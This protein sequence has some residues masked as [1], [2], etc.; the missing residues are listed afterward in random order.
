MRR[1]GA[2]TE[3]ENV[4]KTLIS[5]DRRDTLWDDEI[6]PLEERTLAAPDV[7]DLRQA[8]AKAVKRGRS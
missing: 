6:V 7:D 3:A 2:I 8:V 5:G 4:L 1:L